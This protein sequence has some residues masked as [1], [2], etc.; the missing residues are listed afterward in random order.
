MRNPMHAGKN[1]KIAIIDLSF[2]SCLIFKKLLRLMHTKY[3]I[4]RLL[5]RMQL[6]PLVLEKIAKYT[7]RMIKY[8]NCIYS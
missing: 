3:M 6:S 4:K 1:P 7:S 2:F 8:V 5:K